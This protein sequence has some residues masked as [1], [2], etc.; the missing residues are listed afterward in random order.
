MMK[1]YSIQVISAAPLIIV[2]FASINWFVDPYWFYGSPEI[3][4]LNKSKPL[5]GENPRLFEIVNVLR[6][7]PEV[8]T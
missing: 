1:K 8:L 4:R 3:S 7:K 2:L 6:R 5:A